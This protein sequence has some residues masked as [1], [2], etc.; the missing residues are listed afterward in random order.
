M[1]VARA[2]TCSVAPAN[3]AVEAVSAEARAAGNEKMS[4]SVRGAPAHRFFDRAHESTAD[5]DVLVLPAPPAPRKRLQTVRWR[6]WRRRRLT[7]LRGRAPLCWLM[8]QAEDE[9]DEAAGA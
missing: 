1:E 9:E 7:R 2:A 6:R 8:E 3:C 4:E 5:N